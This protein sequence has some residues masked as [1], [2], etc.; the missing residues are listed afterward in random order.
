MADPGWNSKLSSLSQGVPD[1]ASDKEVEFSRCWGSFQCQFTRGGERKVNV[2]LHIEMDPV[3]LHQAL[4]PD[5]LVWSQVGG[6]HHF[7]S[8]VLELILEKD[9]WKWHP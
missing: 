2:S 7:K 6:K 1:P 8:D 3:A 5:D 9:P 4:K